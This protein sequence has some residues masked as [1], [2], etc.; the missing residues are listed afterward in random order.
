M[1]KKNEEDNDDNEVETTMETLDSSD[2]RR[3]LGR[4]E[5]SASEIL[6]KYK[7][8]LLEKEDEKEK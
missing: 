5:M 7:T 3:K 8:K 1:K 6:L 2:K 4:P